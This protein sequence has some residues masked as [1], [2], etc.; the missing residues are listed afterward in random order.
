[1]KKA[2]GKGL[3]ALLPSSPVGGETVVVELD[4]GK[5]EPNPEQP[6]KN[7]DVEAI[8]QLAESIAAVGVVQPIIVTDEGT[9][10]RIVAGERRWRAARIAGLKEIPAIVRDLSGERRVETAL[11]E[12]LQRKKFR[13]LSGIYPANGVSRRR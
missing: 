4:I 13:Q 5:V 6:R 10:Y 12:N 3:N 1:V 8:G 2:L 7:F 11:I 9:Y